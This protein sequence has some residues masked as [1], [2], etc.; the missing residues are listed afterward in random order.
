M[1]DVVERTRTVVNLDLVGYSDL[2]RGVGGSADVMDLNDQI[3]TYVK[4]GLDA[5]GVPGALVQPDGDGAIVLF[6]DAASAHPFAE[7]VHAAARPAARLFRIGAATGKVSVRRRGDAFDMA[8]SPIADAVRLQAAAAAGTLLVEAVTF[9][10]LSDGVKHL[11][12]KEIEVY[13]KRAE[14][15]QARECVFDPEAARASPRKKQKPP[16]K[17]AEVDEATLRRSL[18][19]L[20][21]GQLARLCSLLLS[22][23]PFAEQ[24]AHDAGEAEKRAALM[25]WADDAGRR[26]ELAGE[27]RELRGPLARY[28]H[29]LE[30]AFGLVELA[31]APVGE[32]LS[33]SRLES[34]YV[35]QALSPRDVGEGNDPGPDLPPAWEVARDEPHLV[36]LGHPGG[37]K[38][39]LVHWIAYQF[40]VAGLGEARADGWPARLGYA[41]DRPAVPLP[42]VLREMRVR[43]G[44]TWDGLWAEF[45]D[46][47][48]QSPLDDESLQPLLKE[49]LGFFLI[50]GLDEVGG[51]EARRSLRDAILEGM[52]LYPKCRWLLTSRI[53]GYEEVPFHQESMSIDEPDAR[54]RVLFPA[55][56]LAP[57][58]DGRIERFATN[59]YACRAAEGDAPGRAAELTKAVS[60]N[61]GTK[62]LAR[63]PF[64]LTQM[65]M[66]HRNDVTLPNGRAKLYARIADAYVEKREEQKGMPLARFPRGKQLECLALVAVRMQ[67]R[68]A[69]A[70]SEEEYEQAL[71]ASDEDV[72]GWLG[73]VVKANAA[74]FL[75]HLGKRTGLLLPRGEE[76]YGFIHLSFLEFFAA[77]FL[78][79]Q[80]LSRAWSK[81]E[82][83]KVP[84]AALPEALGNYAASSRWR[85]VLHFL[86]ELFAA[87]GKL[88]YL[89]GDVFPVLF[90]DG[91]AAVEGTTGDGVDRGALLA[92]LVTDPQAGWEQEAGWGDA[93]RR[94]ALNA[95]LRAEF[96]FQAR[97]PQER[98]Y[99]SSSDI[100]SELM[101]GESERGSVLEALVEEAKRIDLLFL[102]LGNTEATDLGPLAGLTSLQRLS[103][104]DTGVAD[105]GPLA[106]LASLQTLDLRGTKVSA[107][108]VVELKRQLPNCSVYT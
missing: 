66:I 62:G 52:R 22:D 60:A 39:T 102:S 76:R 91:F 12:P 72:R 5:A 89:F 41:A 43:A 31:L 34:L 3:Q 98:G 107:E 1:Y 11:Y 57:F 40:A 47:P 86:C 28:C 14:K 45:L 99:E 19:R 2:C 25:G 71:F 65:A 16:A 68:R 7:A 36:I 48:R 53:V 82:W 18:E 17:P 100:L 26:A 35:E 42:I 104:S 79:E 24:P 15:Y 96:A 32:D 69:G 93:R 80:I 61:A 44:V 85:E 75:G 88:D 23:L 27:A 90:G 74:D 87:D 81:G 58:D 56:Y 10:G 83:Q 108:Q 105:L 20:R 106:G 94:E 55:R 63:I 8:G 92:R 78:K 38:S 70:G 54:P 51:L 97:P 4:A 59:W 9:A 30:R 50:D 73:E 33:R 103:L 64:L 95:C 77:W 21:P 46:Q 67:L 84:G 6:D 29:N 13:G 101:A 37:G 49:G